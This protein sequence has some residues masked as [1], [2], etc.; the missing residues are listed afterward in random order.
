M[1]G[2]GA[3]TC[4]FCGLTADS[5][6]HLL[7]EWLQGLFE[8]EEQHVY[9]REVGGQKTSWKKKGFTEKTKVVCASCNHGWMSQLETVAKE[10]LSPAIAR[11][12]V[13][14]RFDLQSQWVAAEW[15]TKTSYVF[16]GQNQIAPPSRPMLLRMNG[17]PAPQV[18][19]F[20]GSHYRALRDPGNSV[21]MQKPIQAFWEGNDPETAQ[22]FGYLCFLA[23]GGVSFLIVEHRFDEYIEI[24][25]GEQTSKMFDK[26]WPRSTREVHWPPEALMDLEL[27][28]PFFLLDSHPR[29]LDIRVFEGSRC[30]QP[31]FSEAI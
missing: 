8:S 26:I 17:K 2:H 5:R 1:A 28:E 20:L 23:I 19:V 12:M 25:L 13:P 21:Y 14:W 30:H 22:E 31:P 6:E 10:V 3:R 27:I 4:I 24:V 11:S 15:A 16:Q 29:A 18:S 7:P 9:W